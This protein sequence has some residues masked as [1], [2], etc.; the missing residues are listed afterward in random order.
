MA[1]TENG[2]RNGVYSVERRW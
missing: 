1:K 2:H